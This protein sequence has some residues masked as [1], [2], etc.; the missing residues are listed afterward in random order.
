MEDSPDTQYDETEYPCPYAFVFEET[1]LAVDKL[2][3]MEYTIDT[4]SGKIIVDSYTMPDVSGGE[5][6]VE[7]AID[8][9]VFVVD[10]KDS[11]TTVEVFQDRAYFL[12][13]GNECNYDLESTISDGAA[14]DV[15]P[16][17]SVVEELYP[18]IEISY[19]LNSKPINTA[20]AGLCYE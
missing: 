18:I 16:T 9:I 13:G 20:T 8:F 4:A 5:N 12:L 10:T 17:I 1:T 3:G 19:P 7:F 6:A 2:S 11:D 14:K 15:A